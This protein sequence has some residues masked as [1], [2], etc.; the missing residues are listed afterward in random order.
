MEFRD[1][2]SFCGLIFRNCG[3]RTTKFAVSLDISSPRLAQNRGCF[4]DWGA[5]HIVAEPEWAILKLKLERQKAIEQVVGYLN[6]SSGSPDACF[7]GN[8]DSLFA[9]GSAD[10]LPVYEHVLRQLLQATRELCATDNEAFRS[11]EQAERVLKIAVDNVI[12]EYLRGHDAL[13]FH[14]NSDLLLNSFFVAKVLQVV[15]QCGETVGRDGANRRSY[16]VNAE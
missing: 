14:Q 13:L 11:T 3:H 2:K 5:V 9:E 8:L 4:Y 12:P 1:L 16:A 15:L 10:D 6:F 7:H